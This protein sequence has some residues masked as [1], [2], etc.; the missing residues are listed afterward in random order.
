[1]LKFQISYK[2]PLTHILKLKLEIDKIYGDKVNLKLPVWRPGRYEIQN[3]P[4]RIRGFKVADNRGK[5]LSFKKTAKD[6]WTIDIQERTS[7]TVEYEY[8]AGLL[9]GGNT[10]LDDEQLYV[11]PINCCMYEASS[12]NEEIEIELDLPQDYTIASGLKPNGHH[13]LTAKSYY[14]LVDSPIFAS[15]SL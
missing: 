1:M 4:K 3:F 11:N 8:F 7:L 12:M 2:N 13:K 15:A 5:Q 9:D 6:T 14:Q 10:W